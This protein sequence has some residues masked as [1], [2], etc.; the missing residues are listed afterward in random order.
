M[1]DAPAPRGIRPVRERGYAVE[2]P[3]GWQDLTEEPNP[4]L[5]WPLSIWVFDAMRK[6]DAQVK[7][8]LQAVMSPIIRTQWWVDGRGC[9]D[10]VTELVAG[11]LGLPVYGTDPAENFQARLRGRG[12]FSWSHHVRNALGMLP[13]GHS[14]FEQVYYPPEDDGLY[15]LRKLGPRL[16]KTISH[17]EVARDGGLRWIEQ[18]GTAGSSSPT[19]LPVTRLVAY[20]LERE[21]G[22]WLGQS[23]LRPAFKNWHLK[24]EGLRKWLMLIDRNGVGLPLYTAAENEKSL[25]A[26]QEIA[27]AVRAGDNAG[28]AVPYGAKLELI[29]VQGSLPD[30][31]KFVRY[32]DEQIARS[33][34]GHFLNLGSQGGGQVG[35]YNLGSVFADAFHLGLD[36]VADLVATTASAHI[37]EDLVDLNFGPTVPAPRVVYDEVGV[38]MSELDRVRE[39]AGLTSDADLVKLLRTIPEQEATSA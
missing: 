38:R 2:S 30:I 14:F 33:A 9:D 39:A 31:D 21:G 15:H 29:G 28:A 18:Y 35:S 37:I 10:A 32:Q 4:L 8:V 36:A 5:Q 24:D 20:V 7:S 12:R 25:A 19:V 3:T 17:V 11:D 1:P 13:F 6:Q 34:L 23:L 16:P 22:N 26:G 27:S